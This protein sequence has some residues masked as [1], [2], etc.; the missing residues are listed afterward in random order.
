MSEQDTDLFTP[1]ENDNS[2]WL[3]TGC[4]SGF[5]KSIATRLSETGVRL[6]ATAR[7]K[8]ALDYL[9]DA[10]H[11]LKT[12]LDV[13]QP[14]IIKAALQKTIERFGQLDIVVNNAGIGVIGPVEDVTESQTRE[15]F[16][17]NVF[18]VLNVVRAT[19]PIFREQKRGMYINFS[20]MAGISSIDSLGIYSASKFAIEGIS[21]ALI[22]E[23]TPYGVRIMI[24]EP[25]PF[26]T[27]WL[28]KNAIYA[29]KN[30]D[31]YP[32]VWAY[33][34]GMRE[35]YADRKI[36][37][38]PDR[39][40]EKIIAFAYNNDAPTRVPLHEYSLESSKAKLEIIGKDLERAE[41]YS[42]QVHYQDT[43]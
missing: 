32:A 29:P 25:G 24:I 18:G 5:G 43:E 30:E 42:S 33:V 36:V 31:R 37:G 38:D 23:L 26:D 40:A 21:D 7:K 10:D 17:V 16:E 41:G 34:D 15:Q 2:V 22:S 6:V 14:D 39:A 3:V 27:Q 20:S 28:G 8:A 35:V 11:V 12:E 4:S 1:Q 9:P 19:V 13:T